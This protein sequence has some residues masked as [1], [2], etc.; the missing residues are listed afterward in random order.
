MRDVFF[1]SPHD[2]SVLKY[3]ASTPNSEHPVADGSDSTN[4]TQLLAQYRIQYIHYYIGQYNSDSSYKP[5][6]HT[7]WPDLI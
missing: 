6:C 7:K 3:R 4:I 1:V 5:L 2:N